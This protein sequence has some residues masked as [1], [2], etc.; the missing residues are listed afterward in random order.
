MNCPRCN[1]NLEETTIREVNFSIE[2]DKCVDCEGIWFD[3]KELHE[4]EKVS[5]PTIWELKRIPNKRAQLKA[6]NC[7][8][9][10]DK[11]LLKKAEHPR[12][13]A[14]ILDYCENCRGIWLDKGELEAIQKE[15]WLLV[16]RNLVSKMLR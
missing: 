10:E 3:E 2:V 16:I 1:G 12:D 11:P 14:V 5:E 7:P 13:Q 15:N 4:I 8:K 6:M 9:C